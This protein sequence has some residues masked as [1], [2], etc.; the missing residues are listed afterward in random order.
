MKQVYPYL[1]TTLRPITDLEF[2]RFQKLIYQA[3]GIHLAPHKRALLE[4][5]LSKRIRALGLDSF[6][7]YYKLVVGAETGDELIRLLNHISTNETRFFREPKQLEFL[8][9][10]VFDEW[11]ARAAMG[12]MPKRIRL[13]SAGC[14][15]GEEAYSIA[16]LL[17]DKL[18]RHN[19]WD[20][21]ILATDLSTRSLEIAH[22]GIWPIVKA[23]EIPEKYLKLYMWR[24]TGAQD[25]MMKAGAEI[26]S[27]IHFERL[28]LND[29]RYPISG[30][31]DA[32]F[33]RN[34]LI[35]FDTSS[36]ARVI[37]RLID[38]LTPAGYLFVGHAE[39]L[40]GVTDRA[41]HVLPTI[42]RAT[43]NEFPR[44]AAGDSKL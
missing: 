37:D 35:Y 36:R 10:E 11:R 1:K 26:R 44:R 25:G 38:R 29:Q 5:R 30:R 27:L 18:P 2:S 40:S 14:A 4:A 32:I 22:E 42:Y 8:E 17:L 28:N 16:M 43:P 41:Q 15:S 39:S 19:G 3:A 13:W 23:Q 9:H 33:C 34:V 24:G 6:D 7:A 12:L 20:V 21:E 31:F